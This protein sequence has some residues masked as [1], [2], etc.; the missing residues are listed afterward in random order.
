MLNIA[1]KRSTK[2]KE[3]SQ[4]EKETLEEEK[5][6][7]DRSTFTSTNQRRNW[8]CEAVCLINFETNQC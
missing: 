1:T 2:K 8:N 5:V 4:T 6:R 7:A 3:K